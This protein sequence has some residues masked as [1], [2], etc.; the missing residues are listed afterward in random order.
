MKKSR[1]NFTLT[2]LAVSLVCI[3]AVFTLTVS[4]AHGAMEQA[5]SVTCMNKLKNIGTAALAYAKNNSSFIPCR[6]RD[7]KTGAVNDFG[8]WFQEWS[9]QLIWG[10]YFGEKPAVSYSR[11]MVTEGKKYFGCPDD[12]ELA[13]N[14]SP[15][16][17]YIFFTIN[18]AAIELTPKRYGF[19]AEDYARVVVG[20]DRAE[21]SIVFDYFPY[22][23]SSFKK[24]VHGKTANVLRLNG[25]VDSVDITRG[26]RTSQFYKWI[27]EDIDGIEL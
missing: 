7:A 8:N 9:K 3:A 19:S 26:R 15:K 25:T 10:G 16:G 4:V 12:D 17:S 21:N 2:E 20:R 18:R 6:V 24:A 1:K 14:K 23:G 11:G 5:K 13:T 22:N 27:G